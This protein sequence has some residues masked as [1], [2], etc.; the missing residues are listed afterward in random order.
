MN[1][2]QIA[3]FA[4]KVDK[5]GTDECWEW[6]A[7]KVGGTGY[8][9][10]KIEGKTYRAHRVSWELFFGPI[11]KNMMVLHKCNNPSCVNPY[12]LYLGDGI[13]N[14]VDRA[15][16]GHT[17]GGAPVGQATGYVL[18]DED[19]ERI[20]ILLQRNVKQVDIARMFAISQA[21]VS[22]IKLGQYKQRDSRYV[23]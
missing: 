11:P 23:K 19:I 22:R 9:K 7:G 20:H 16:A 6:E 5:R 8:G 13:D 17:R 12:H 21:H 2:S 14:A 4:E 15:E 18:Y 1:S 10:V 3:S